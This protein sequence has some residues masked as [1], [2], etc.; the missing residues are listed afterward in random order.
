MARRRTLGVVLLAVVA[1]FGALAPRGNAQAPPTITLPPVTPTT[2]PPTSTT[3]PGSTSETTVPPDTS[4]STTTTIDVSQDGDNGSPTGGGPGQ[5][6]PPDAQAVIDALVRSGANDNHLL[7]AGEKALLA[8]GVDP[9]QA[10]R[11]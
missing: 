6:I 4:S 8:A 2:P 11:L 1:V 7:V 10:A 3:L 5:V 9:D